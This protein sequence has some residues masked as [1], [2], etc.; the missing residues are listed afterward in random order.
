MQVIFRIM[1]VIFRFMQVIFRI[2]QVISLR[3]CNENNGLPKL[4]CWRTHFARTNLQN[5]ML[6]VGKTR[7]ED[8]IPSDRK[9]VFKEIPAGQEWR[10]NVVKELS[11]VKNNNL[12]VS[13]FELEEI[14][15]MLTWICTTGPS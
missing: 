2:M 11:D 14:K 15:T 12:E 13:G 4:L 6:R 7:I 9:V 10:I 8:I 1:Q 5:I 3:F